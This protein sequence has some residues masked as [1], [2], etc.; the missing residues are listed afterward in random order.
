MFIEILQIL[1]VGQDFIE[2]QILNNL[3]TTES[4]GKVNR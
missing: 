4:L 3:N 2:S 1:I